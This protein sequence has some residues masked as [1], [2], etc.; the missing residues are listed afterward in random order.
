MESILTSIKKLLG[1]AEDYEHFD[2]DIIMHTNSVFTIL[3]QLGVGP[4]EGFFIED[5]NSKWSDF[6][7][8]ASAMRLKMVTSYVYLRVRLLFDPPTGTV[9]EAIK[10]QIKEF[11]WRLNVA[12]ESTPGGS[13]SGGSG[14]DYEKLENLPSINGEKLIGNYNEKDPT[15]KTMPSSDVDNIWNELF[16]D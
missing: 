3:T 10:E 4:S 1:I 7:P 5:K 6:L 15:V 12:A 16:K 14:I 11:E 8:D 2:Q 9:L 13:S